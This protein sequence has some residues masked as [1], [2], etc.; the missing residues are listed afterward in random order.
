MP[1]SRSEASGSAAWLPGF[2]VVILASIIVRVVVVV[3][4]RPVVDGDAPGYLNLARLI[5]HGRMGEFQGM[6]T[7]GYSVFLILNAFNPGAVRLTQYAL[8]LTL[9]A[10]LFFVLWQLTHSPWLS[11]IGAA[12]YGLNV[13][14]VY[15]ESTLYTETLTTFFL[16]LLLVLLVLLRRNDRHEVAL[17]IALGLTI[18]ILPLVRPLYSYMPLLFAVPVFLAVK[19]RR[20]RFLLYVLPALIP[21]VMWVGYEYAKYDYLGFETVSGF[22]WTNHAGAFM[23]DAPVSDE[24]I[25]GIYLRSVAARGGVWTNAIWPAI[26]AMERA[27]G[28]SYPELSKTVQRLS[29]GLLWNHPVGYARQVALG[30][31]DFW[32]GSIYHPIWSAFGR[33]RYPAWKLTFLIAVAVSAWF[34]SA[35]V[36][37]A[38]VLL[39]TGRPPRL[40]WPCVW[41]AMAVLVAAIV[42]A[43]VEYGSATRF[44]MP[45]FPYVIVVAACAFDF[46]VLKRSRGG[47]VRD[48]EAAL[49]DSANAGS[50]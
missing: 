38:V 6:R 50:K 42:Q 47:G 40:P 37:I 27:T 3:T 31:V 24:P 20:R 30:F 7:P 45:T 49:P 34:C 36:W 9:T 43:V 22:G 11:A 13:G 41:L 18:G 25:K 5:W 21:I 29:L 12:L 44:G 46:W 14:H 26:P 48:E 2:V 32:K 1:G 4:S 23:R 28:Q 15:F 19:R 33:F 8:G 16:V 17:L 10:G 39:R 35:V